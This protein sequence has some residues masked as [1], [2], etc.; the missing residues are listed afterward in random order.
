MNFVEKSNINFENAIGE[1]DERQRFMGRDLDLES[2]MKSQIEY[3]VDF[4]KARAGTIFIRDGYKLNFGY[5]VNRDVP[6][7]RSDFMYSNALPIDNNSIAGRVAN[8]DK[9]LLLRDAYDVDYFNKSFDEKSGFRTESVLAVPIRSRVGNNIGVL[10]LINKTLDGKVVEFNNTDKNLAQYLA[11]HYIGR[12]IGDGISNRSSADIILSMANQFDKK[13]TAAHTQRV[14]EFSKVLYIEYARLNKIS[15]EEATK[16]TDLLRLGAPLH[17][18]GK[19]NIPYEILKLDRKLSTEEFEKI[20]PHTSL[21]EQF[22]RTN[23]SQK[24]P[25]SNVSAQIAGSHH[26]K[27]DGRGYPQKLRGE[28]I[29]LGGRIVAVADVYDALRSARSYKPGWSHDEAMREIVKG[30][31]VHFDPKLV[32]AFQN[33]HNI[34]NKISE[35]YS[36][37]IK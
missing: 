18:V 15:Q 11:Y 10:M 7:D 19:I 17:D 5:V 24:Y 25:W 33:I 35:R 2:L 1:I 4:F 14:G 3:A 36:D 30:S 6:Q 37:S 27:W 22:L 13:E 29:P 8:E 26:E 9:S 20:M 32:H 12:D 28:E 34:F 21:G 16:M 31:G 23:I